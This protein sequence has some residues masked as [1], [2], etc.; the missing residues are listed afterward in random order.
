MATI[1][2]NELVAGDASA[3]TPILSKLKLEFH[4]HETSVNELVTMASEYLVDR[5]GFAA[6]ESASR[7]ALVL[8]L[9]LLLIATALGSV[10]FIHRRA[11]KP[12]GEITDFMTNMASGD[13][14]ATVGAQYKFSRTW[15]VVGE[16]EAGDGGETYLVGLR[17]SF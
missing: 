1:H 14:T 5:E 4:D 8:T 15:G 17:A 2:A 6:A 3:I 16:I 7:E 10:F 12:L 13:F 9:G 11:L